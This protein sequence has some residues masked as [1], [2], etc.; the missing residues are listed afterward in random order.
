MIFA[1]LAADY[2]GTLAENGHV[3][4]STM[5]ALRRLKS[6]GMRL[7][8][9]TGRWLEDLQHAFDAEDLIDAVVAENGAVVFLPKVELTLQIGGPPPHALVQI[10]H[11]RGVP[12]SIGRGI[13][14]T[15]QPHQM[16][17]LEAIRELGLDWHVVLNKGAAMVLPPGVNKATG[18][19][20]ALV[21]LELSP[22]AVVGI[23][24]AEND[25]AFLAWCGC[26]VAVANALPALKAAADLITKGEDGAGVRELIDS[27]LR[28]E[29]LAFGEL[30]RRKLDVVGPGQPVRRRR[31]VRPAI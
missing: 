22:Q 28:D 1:A 27:W 31:D 12:H 11:D 6:A 9:V 15:S 29:E 13:I 18:L 14:S 3:A 30:V 19:K 20:A 17:A 23:G 2:D 24:D 4:A 25:Q 8:V 26:S 10:L 16:T 5:E 7:I 21:E